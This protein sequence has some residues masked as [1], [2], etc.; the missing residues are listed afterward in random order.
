[1]R[2][3]PAHEN[4]WEKSKRVYIREQHQGKPDPKALL[5][6][7]TPTILIR[8]RDY[9]VTMRMSFE[10]IWRKKI[11]AMKARE[12]TTTTKGSLEQTRQGG[13][14]GR[15]EEGRREEGR[16]EGQSRLLEA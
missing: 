10:E 14:E 8:K 2:T 7:P 3:S 11:D 9:L 5:L 6:Q 4:F 12:R 13:R 1:M 16:R 15:R